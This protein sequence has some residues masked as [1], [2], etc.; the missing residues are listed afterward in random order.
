MGL[1]ARPFCRH[2]QGYSFIELIVVLFISMLLLLACVALP[3]VNVGAK[4]S[5]ERLV[6]LLRFSRFYALSHGGQVE[7]CASSDGRQCNA[8]WGAGGLVRDMNANKVIYQWQEPQSGCHWVFNGAKWLQSR[9][10]FNALGLSSGSQGSFR[11]SGPRCYTGF[12]VVV[13]SSG[14]AR[15]RKV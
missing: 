10:V 13:S 5:A 15:I 9:I 12:R 11:F 8:K 1:S 2:E 14:R 7:V 6:A 3:R 4:F